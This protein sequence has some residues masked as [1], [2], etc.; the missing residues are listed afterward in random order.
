MCMA[1]YR[2]HR[3]LGAKSEGLQPYRQAITY[4]IARRVRSHRRS[5][6]RWSWQSEEISVKL[7]PVFVSAEFDNPM[8]L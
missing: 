8:L 3:L 1:L 6:S 5:I 4:G 2:R 7:G